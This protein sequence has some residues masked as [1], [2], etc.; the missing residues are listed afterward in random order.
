MQ[1]AV[2]RNPTRLRG[3]CL[4]LE[5]IQSLLNAR[6]GLDAQSIGVGA[7]RRAIQAR[8]HACGALGAGQYWQQL[9]GSADELQAL[10]ELVIVPETWFFRDPAAFE[11]L[12]Q[13]SVSRW[14]E[15][16]GDAPLR[17]L[18]LPCASGEEPY[19][20]AM[21][22][23]DHGLQP[24]QFRIDALDVSHRA[25][26]TARR[27]EYGRNAF[28]G[29]RLE[30]RARYFQPSE[31]SYRLCGLARRAVS[32][33]T[34]SL[35]DSAVAT[36][37]PGFDVIF[38]RNLL[39]YFDR[40]HQQAA[41]Q[42][43]DRLLSRNGTLFVGP[44][45]GALLLDH[46]FEPV[47]VSR[48]FCFQRPPIPRRSL[49]PGNAPAVPEG[50]LVP[51]RHARP[52]AGGVG[53]AAR[54]PQSARQP[55]PAAPSAVPGVPAGWIEAA[56]RLADEGRLSEALAVCARHLGESPSADAYCLSAVIHDAAGQASLALAHYRRALYLDPVHE[57]ALTHLAAA[58]M[59]DGNSDEAQ[60]LLAR[61]QRARRAEG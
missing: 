36:A 34:A 7:L 48:A 45:E 60:R 40:Q 46:G 15:V 37:A 18:S 49:P 16:V 20:M 28:R 56:K 55:P 30:F 59:R 58:L 25:I 8:G 61:A 41:L 11:A 29:D 2:G 27:A 32:F 57:E 4:S 14:R 35:F 42:I 44:S 1:R 53:S 54:R 22:L 52:G 10:I 23:L 24:E 38:C 12:I 3:G 9:Q 13:V 33:R 50:R 26:H 5:R 47:P 31:R 6:I 17:L 21:A 19:S 51:R 39:I 43:L